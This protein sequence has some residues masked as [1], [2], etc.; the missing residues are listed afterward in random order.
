V[1]AT[2]DRSPGSTCSDAAAFWRGGTRQVGHLEKLLREAIG[3][4]LPDVIGFDPFIKTHALEENDNGQAQKRWLSGSNGTERKS[5]LR[6]M[7]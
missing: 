3:R 7:M 5:V 1:Q 6:S 4:R 2:G